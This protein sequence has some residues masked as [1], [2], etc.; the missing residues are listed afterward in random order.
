[1][2]VGGQRHPRILVNRNLD[3]PRVGVDFLRREKF[4]SSARI[5]NLDPAAC[6]LAM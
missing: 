6:S 1:M 2:E 3:G 4:F 5:R